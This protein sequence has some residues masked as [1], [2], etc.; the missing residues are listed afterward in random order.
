MTVSTGTFVLRIRAKMDFVR[1]ISLLRIPQCVEME[2]VKRVK[3]ARTV[4]TVDRENGVV[5]GT[6]AAMAV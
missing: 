6:T 5:A 3:T 2:N 4:Q 1:M